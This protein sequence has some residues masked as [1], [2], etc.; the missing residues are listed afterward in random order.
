MSASFAGQISDLAT[1]KHKPSNA[2]TMDNDVHGLALSGRA[3]SV[4]C[5]DG[6]VCIPAQQF[7]RAG[8]MLK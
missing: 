1:L 7:D 6:G 4:G 5:F 3:G 2:S 8:W